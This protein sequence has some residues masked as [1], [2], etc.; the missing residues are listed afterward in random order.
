MRRSKSYPLLKKAQIDSVSPP[1]HL[2]D[3]SKLRFYLLTFFFKFRLQF[4]Q[5]QWFIFVHE[6]AWWSF[7][8]DKCIPPNSTIRHGSILI[9]W[10]SY[11]VIWYYVMS[12]NWLGMVKFEISRL[13]I[14]LVQWNLKLR[15]E[16]GADELSLTPPENKI[17]N[18]VNDLPIVLIR[19]RWFLNDLGKRS[20]TV[21][22]LLYN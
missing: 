9:I 6:C 18:L 21:R 5:S 12:C 7:L 11:H 19:S 14:R 2:L 22:Q 15:G 3:R 13:E 4:V 20:Q 1:I 8:H 10:R 17:M 16:E